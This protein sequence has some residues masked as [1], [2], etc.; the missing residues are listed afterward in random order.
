MCTLH[1][2]RLWAVPGGKHAS[3]MA[4]SV[5]CIASGSHCA[6]LYAAAQAAHVG[7]ECVDALLHSSGLAFVVSAGPE[8]GCC[9]DGTA[10]CPRRGLLSDSLS[11]FG[12]T[13]VAVVV[14]STLS[15]CVASMAWHQQPG[16]MQFGLCAAAEQLMPSR[17]D[18]F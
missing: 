5:Q 11:C 6:V 9:R 18:V 12:C 16:S 7:T 14:M 10:Q 13:H 1:C 3:C 4:S 15:T 8:A 17:P 2:V